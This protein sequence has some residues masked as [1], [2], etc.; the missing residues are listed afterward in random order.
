MTKDDKTKGPVAP[1]VSPDEELAPPIEP[2][3]VV[4]E[5]HEATE[6]T[7]DEARVEDTKAVTLD[8]LINAW[9]TSEN[10]N[11]VDKVRRLKMILML[12]REKV[13]IDPSKVLIRQPRTMGG[14][15]VGEAH[16]REF[17][18]LDG[19]LFAKKFTADQLTILR[20]VLLH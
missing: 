18:E 19:I 7:L 2:D 11:A 10:Q 8:E 5:I 14:N 17:V 1:E 15:V 6:Q 9:E 20:H 13:D 3:S 16:G 12:V 4:D